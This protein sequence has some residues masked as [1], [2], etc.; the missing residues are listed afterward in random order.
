MRIILIINKII[1]KNPICIRI[2]IINKSKRKWN[3]TGTKRTWINEKIN[4]LL[5]IKICWWRTRLTKIRK[6]K[7]RLNF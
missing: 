6:R 7:K 1:T 3:I 2:I 5:T 4:K